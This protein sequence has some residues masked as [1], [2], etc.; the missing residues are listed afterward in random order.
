MTHWSSTRKRGLSVPCSSLTEV[1]M[2]KIYFWNLI[3][4]KHFN[5]LHDSQTISSSL[6]SISSC[7]LAVLG[8]YVAV[9]VPVSA[10]SPYS[11]PLQCAFCSSLSRERPISCPL[12]LGWPCV[13]HWPIE[14]DASDFGPI[15]SPRLKR[16]WGLALFQPLGGCASCK[17]TWA[18]QLANE[19]YVEESQQ[20]SASQP[21]N[22]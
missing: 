17:P 22:M 11:P 16:P 8:S 4:V 13:L 5:M 21:P 20:P 3:S 15:L 2:K 18:S 6:S 14:W 12:I 7:G 10:L 9:T 1:W 19:I